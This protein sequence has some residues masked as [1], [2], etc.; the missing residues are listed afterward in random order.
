MKRFFSLGCLREDR[1]IS[2]IEFALVA[3]FLCTFVLAVVDLSFG[4]QAKMAVTQAAQAGTYY[5]M[6][7]GYNTSGIQTAVA[8][9]SGTSGITAPST[10]QTCGCPSGT[11]VTTTTCGNSCPNG[12]TA[13]TYVT[14]NA[15]YQYSTILTY[16][17]LP[18]PMTLTST[19]MLRI[20]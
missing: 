11:A 16:P 19:S 3:P 9:S 13:G 14:V 1:G 15:Q 2:A 7:N 4:F 17:G 20:K 8:S 5:A 12:Q 18:S 6:L 10:A